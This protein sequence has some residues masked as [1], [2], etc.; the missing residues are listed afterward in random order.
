MR[1]NPAISDRF[2]E[3]LFWFLPRRLML[4]VLLS[5]LPVVLRAQAHRMPSAPPG[6]VETG[7]PSFAVLG[8]E[9]LGLDAPP[10]DIRLMPDGRVL[11]VA[12]QQL[13]LGDGV[14][15]EVFRQAAT[16][17]VMPALG[18]G[19]DNDGK[20][21]LGVPGGGARVNFGEDALW[22]LIRSTPALANS[23]STL[24]VPQTVTEAGRQ[25]FWHSSSGPVVAWRPGQSAQT[26]GQVDTFE[27]VFEFEGSCYLSDRSAG[28]LSRLVD[29]K[30]EEVLANGTLSAITC[31]LSYDEKLMLVGTYGLGLQFF[32]GKSTRPFPASGLLAP[33]AR[34]NDLRNVEGGLIAAAVDNYGVVVFTREGRPVQVLDR[35]LDHRLSGVKRLL[36]AA[37]GV[38]WGLMDGGVLRM[39]FP[40]RLSHFEPMI[41][42][43]ITT[44]HPYRWDNRLWLLADGKMHQGKY[45]SRGRLSRME[46]DSPA[47]LFV[48]TFSVATGVPV[49]GTEQGAYYLTPSG[50]VSFAP[51]LN[52]LRVIGSAPVNGRWLYG[53]HNEIGWLLPL[54]GAIEV[55]ERIPVPAFGKIYNSE[56]DEKGRIWL[57]LG[58]GRVGRIQFGPDNKPSLEVFS[59]N[60]GVPQ[61][62]GQIFEIGGIVRFNFAE[63][64]LFFD[65]AT[66]RFLPDEE[67]TR[68]ISGL[69]NIIGRP[70]LDARG[71]LWVTSNGLVHVFERQGGQWRATEPPLEVGF[72]PYYFTFESGDVV[73]MHALHRLA[74]YDP[75]APEPASVPLRA[76]ITQVNLAGS[77]RVLNPKEVA[78][79]PLEYLENSLVAH[80]VSSG[81]PFA[82]R[83][84]FEVMLEGSSE[85]WVTAG[86]A[87]SAAFS[88]LKEGRYVLRVR[89][90]SGSSVGAEDTLA[91]SIR[92]PWY[93]TT[94]AY[95][96]YGLSA[97]GFVLLAVWLSTLLERR[98]NA[99]LE[100]LVA[101]RTGELSRSNMQLAK[102]V[103]EI[104]VL[105]QAIMQSPIAVF[106]TKP[107]GIVEFTNPRS[108]QLTGLTASHLIGT[109]LRQ[110][111]SPDVNVQIFDD[112]SAA[113]SAGNSWSGELAYRHADGHL[114]RVRSS[115]S[116]ILSPDG[117]TRHHLVLEEDITEWL[118]DQQ[119][120][121]QLETQLVQ[122]QKMESIGTLAGGIA[123]D[124]NNI[125]TG[126]LG[127]CEIARMVADDKGDVGPELQQIRTAGL[128]A[129]D[130]VMQILTF[131]RQSNTKLVPVDLS[132]PVAEALK[133]VRASTPAT[134]EITQELASGR[135]LA[136]ATQIHQVIIN[137]CTN[138]VH[139]MKNRSGRLNVMLSNILVDRSLAA[140]V[141]NFKPGPS[142]R[143]TV[144]DNGH[145]MDQAT[146]ER[147][148]DPFFTT[149]SH[150][151]GT[152]LGLAIVQGVVASHGGALQVSSRIGAGTIFD[153]YFPRTEAVESAAPIVLEPARG[154][155]EEIMVVDDEPSVADF[156][157]SVLKRFGYRPV[158]FHEPKLAF[159][160]F[161]AA[162]DRFAAIVTDLTMPH[163]TGLDL[164]ELVRPERPM[165]PVLILTG[166]SR[167]LTREKI[168]TLS[169]CVLLQKPFSGEDLA[170]ALGLV[171]QQSRQPGGSA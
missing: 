23:A 100:R 151:E 20:I 126:I 106:I 128:R 29:G 124:F 28:R 30:M 131:S 90:R 87:G 56:S 108:S 54:N 133:L 59:A 74:R 115:I 27:H 25:W 103:E 12:G 9:S 10:T 47:Q 70:G 31:A 79:R 83:V 138:A 5:L 150:G 66:R 51:M 114:V 104:R 169:H 162:P 93:R 18:A 98:E 118:A 13:A 158:V 15:W 3:T 16:D 43:G 6:L 136:D 84:T 105:T 67:F 157:T 161:A 120:R 139:A 72:Q 147:I 48:S 45:D 144:A 60:D 4:V 24:P 55:I 36:P 68:S 135:I 78:L 119:R 61:S 149:K 46:I 102:Q 14:R 97:L 71:R 113:L 58:A 19:V 121:R 132:V 2:I 152:G 153:L 130:L 111:R 44:A 163:L 26:V 89:P 160:A 1:L 148:F 107:D 85:E 49:A 69:T 41:G 94:V 95:L 80:F 62:W 154:A 50:W 63:H 76:L 81:N 65:E 86:S 110:L 53:A 82:T 165:I 77:N 171:I 155:G 88:K 35:S 39:K 164:V 73:W 168:A 22:R 64:I 142:L 159:A 167:E 42:T 127:Y 146:L 123:H 52:N 125:L 145:G 156:S 96:A 117:T 33:G 57:E 91:F 92:P 32:D 17:V 137:L 116:P 166:Y 109:N 40:S 129:K 11:V 99:R 8:A 37:G 134:V 140:T 122:A 7:A 34:I 75:A 101:E 21:Y 112:I 143:L 141:P 170:Q 38:V